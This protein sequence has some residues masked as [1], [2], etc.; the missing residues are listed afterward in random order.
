[1]ADEIRRL[2]ARLG[3]TTTIFRVQWPGLEQAAALQTIRLLGERIL[4]RV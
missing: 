4:P 3:A 1:V 2:Q